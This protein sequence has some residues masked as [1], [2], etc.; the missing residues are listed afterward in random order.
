MVSERLLRDVAVIEIALL[1]AGWLYLLVQGSWS[2][3]RRARARR[4]RAA[5]N[6]V[7]A[8]LEPRALTAEGR[9]QLEALPRADQREVLRLLARNLKGSERGWLTRLAGELQLIDRALKRCESR[10]WWRRM[11]GARHL[12]LLGGSGNRLL[13]MA[14]DPHPLVRAQVA[15]WCGGTPTPAAISTLVGMLGDPDRASRFAVQDALSRLD[16]LV[17]EAL[18]GELMRVDDAT[19]AKAALLVARAIGDHELAEAVERLTRH[20]SPGVRA[21]AYSAFGM[22]GAPGGSASLEDGLR[23]EKSEVRAAAALALGELGRWQ[24]GR[25]VVRCLTDTSWDVRLA[26]GRSLILMGPPGQL[27]LR[28][29]LA[30]ENPFAADMARHTLDVAL[31]EGS[32]P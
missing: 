3:R 8:G 15:K 4:L 23:D 25:L 11:E 21:A 31:V 26:A 30:H 12:T 9:A 7:A 1:V 14:D 29:A 27:L 5:R 2:R 22:T 28:R 6:L 10:F 18:V 32:A 24:E 16:N 17:T 13:R 20:E 19:E